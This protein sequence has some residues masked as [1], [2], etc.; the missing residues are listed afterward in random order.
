MTPE[1]RALDVKIN[2]S[3]TGT[4]EM[5][6]YTLNTVCDLL[7]DVADS[8]AEEAAK[9][10][11]G[12]DLDLTFNITDVF[13]NSLDVTVHEDPKAQL[14]EIC[15]DCDHPI[16]KHTNAKGVTCLIAGCTCTTSAA[17]LNG[18][19]LGFPRGCAVNAAPARGR[20]ALSLAHQV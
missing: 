14:T 12:N 3:I 10:V 4:I 7:Y 15:P 16:E 9:R 11:D 17:W 13:G 18:D 20:R 6:R 8:L 19:D 1:R 5:P 2:L